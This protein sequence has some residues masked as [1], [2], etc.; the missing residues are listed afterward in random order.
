V[1]GIYAI[2]DAPP[3]TMPATGDLRAVDC[4]GLVA[5]CGPGGERSVTADRL[6]RHEQV[7]ETLMKT[8]DLLPVR[9]GMQVEDEPTAA[10]V[11]ARRRAE[12]LEALDRVRGA[13][14]L[15]VRVAGEPREADAVAPASGA[16]YLRAKARAAARDDQ[17]ADRVHKPLER[18]ARAGRRRPGRGRELLCAAYLVDREAVAQF[19][20]RVAQLQRE[21]PDLKV[22]CTGPWP[23]YSFVGE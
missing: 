23:P 17:I 1:I 20:E 16:E 22:L 18:M 12:L 19:G 6:W 8:C 9:Y 2:T 14:E 7:V 15:S 21:H 4:G 5:F 3:A 11:L 13:V 10:R